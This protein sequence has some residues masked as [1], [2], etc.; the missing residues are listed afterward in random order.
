MRGNAE[1]A[2]VSTPRAQA[3]GWRLSSAGS[4]CRPRCAAASP[5]RPHRRGPYGGWI[6]G[7]SAAWIDGEHARGGSGTTLSGFA[8]CVMIGKNHI[9]TREGGVMHVQ[10]VTYRLGEISDHEFIEA[11]REFADMMAAVPGL[12][13]KVWLKDPDGNT[14]GG[15]YLW[16]DRQACEAF[17]SGELW[18][19]V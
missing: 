6:Q 9:S 7:V 10:V 12:L 5:C 2:R 3:R 17:V 18:G 15:V 14:Y 4:P 1:A 11:N 13:A 8:P 16:Q 19:E